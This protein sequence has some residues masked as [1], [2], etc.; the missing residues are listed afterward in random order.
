MARHYTSSGID[1]SGTGQTAE[2]LDDYEE[3]TYLWS[4]AS[5]GTGSWAVRSQYN[6]AHYCKIAG[7]CFVG[8]RLETTT[9]WTVS[10]GTTARISL[11]FAVSDLGEYS[12]HAYMGMA[13][14]SWGTTATVVFGWLTEGTSYAE[15]YKI[16][17]DD[18]IS[19]IEPD[20]WCEWVM[21]GNYPCA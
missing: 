11:P 14:W 10:G 9:G 6:R 16:D 2:T 7:H 15:T 5:D 18:T 17:D 3:G 13:H 4:M 21:S 1:F 12:G 19:K 20:Q 8:G